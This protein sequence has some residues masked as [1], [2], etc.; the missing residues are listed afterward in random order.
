M[1]LSS[2]AKAFIWNVI[3]FERF[4]LVFK[5]LTCWQTTKSW[6]GC[7]HLSTFSKHSGCSNSEIAWIGPLFL[8]KSWRGDLF[9][10]LGIV[11]LQFTLSYRSKGF[12][13]KRGWFFMCFREEWVS[14]QWYTD[15]KSSKEIFKSLKL[16][17][18]KFVC[19]HPGL[20][21]FLWFSFVDPQQIHHPCQGVDE[22]LEKPC[23]SQGEPTGVWQEGAEEQWLNGKKFILLLF[24]FY[25]L[26]KCRGMHSHQL[27]SY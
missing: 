25:L 13:G 11:C 16:P 8:G 22:S 20:F 23:S 27:S 17:I 26:C 14:K 7:Q 4:N 2:D 5:S 6:D 19:I 15:P 9:R 18:W 24:L 12:R 21:L 1:L 3:D 10:F